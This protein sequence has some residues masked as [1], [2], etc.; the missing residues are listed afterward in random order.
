MM[1]QGRALAVSTHPLLPFAVRRWRIT[2]LQ[3]LA[4]A[5]ALI[6]DSM[7]R[8]PAVAA[9]FV[10]VLV[11]ALFWEA[12]FAFARH[13]DLTAHGLPTAILVALFLPLDVATWQPVLAVSLGVVLAE[14]VFGGRGF[15]FVSTAAASLVLLAVSFPTLALHPTTLTVALACLPGLAA[16]LLAGIVSW[17]VLIATTLACISAVALFGTSQLEVVPILVALSIG[18]VFLIADPV[19]AA[20]T[21]PGRWI[22]GALAGFLIAV[23]SGFSSASVPP[24]SM[25]FAA[26]L[27]SL[28]A[29]LIDHLVVLGNTARRQRWRAHHDG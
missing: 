20:T 29:P 1:F 27:A 13:T 5:P 25:V 3:A 17:Q 19:A 18:L 22:Y 10:V 24:E 11:T 6:A 4:I 14:L 7:A 15:G 28:F 26:L 9:L 16:L 21:N 2:L 23:F 12:L 8:G